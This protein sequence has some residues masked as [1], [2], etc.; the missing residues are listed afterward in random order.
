MH[1]VVRSDWLLKLGIVSAIRLQAF[2]W[3][4]GGGVSLISQKKRTI[5]CWLSTDLAYTKTIIPLSVGEE[6]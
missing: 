5:W 4:S 2:F 6:W 3:I 1:S